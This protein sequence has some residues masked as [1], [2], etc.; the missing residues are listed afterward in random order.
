MNGVLRISSTYAATR[1]RSH[2]MWLWC[3]AAAVGASF[4]GVDILYD[5]DAQPIVLEVNSM[6]AW[7]GLQKVTPVDIASILATDLLAAA[8]LRAPLG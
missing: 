1:R 8:G 5:A 4:A 6:P 3:A 2:A 7:S